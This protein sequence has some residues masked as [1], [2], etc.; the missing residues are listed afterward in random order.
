LDQTIARLAQ[1]GEVATSFAQLVLSEL[2]LVALDTLDRIC[3]ETVT[4][5]RYLSITARRKALHG[6][7]MR[8]RR[9]RLP[10]MLV[11][12]DQP[13]AAP[14]VNEL[15]ELLVWQPKSSDIRERLSSFAR[16]QVTPGELAALAQD[17]AL[18][19]VTLS[20][21]PKNWLLFDRRGNFVD[22]VV[23]EHGTRLL[24]V[25]ELAAE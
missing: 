20:R 17:A 22:V 7:F 8:S 1:H 4:G 16:A 21:N 6:W 2:P 9:Q 25:M 11:I 3:F 5:Q 10:I 15:S 13:F 23:S 14:P 19:P 18:S 12:D 24:E